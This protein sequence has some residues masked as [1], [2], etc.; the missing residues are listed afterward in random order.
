MLK[1]Y[2]IYDY[3]SIDGAE[4]REVGGYGEKVIDGEPKSELRLDK[5]SF[6]KAYEYLTQHHLSGV[7]ND[8]T[9]FRKKP[10]IQVSYT[11]TLDWITYRHFDTISYKREY[12]EWKD[13][14]LKWLMEHASAEQTIQYLKERGMTA[15]PIL[16]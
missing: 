3:V 1:V 14:P 4:W 8:V 7:Y 11:D 16:K 10:L 2:H 6:N 12:K 15:C 13:V 9:L 5:A